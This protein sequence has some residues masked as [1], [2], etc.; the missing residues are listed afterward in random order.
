V[1]DFH[2]LTGTHC[3][4]EPQPCAGWGSLVT[5]V[6]A[7]VSGLVRAALQPVVTTRHTVTAG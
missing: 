1:G 5:G 7:E 2:L 3:F 4:G 6:F